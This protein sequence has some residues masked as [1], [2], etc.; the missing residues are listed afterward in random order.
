MRTTKLILLLLA[1]LL[2]GVGIGVL[3]HTALIRARIRHFSQIPG[4]VPGHIT[5]QLT[6]RLGL[7]AGQQAHVR[8][9]LERFDGRLQQARAQSRATFKALL[10]EMRAEVAALLTSEQRAEHAELLEEIDKRREGTR[11]LRRALRPP[12]DLNT[13]APPDQAK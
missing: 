13:A 12:P 10:D 1:T 8:V 11:A 6:R 2:A 7:D 5:D 9:I 3:G 4:N